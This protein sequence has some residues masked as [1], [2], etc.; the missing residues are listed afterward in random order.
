MAAAHFVSHAL[1]HTGLVRRRNEDAV[2]D[3]PERGLWAVADGMGGHE[4]GDYASACIAAAL[5]GLELPHSFDEFVA[6]VE[7]CLH[8]V[9]G[10]LRMRASRLGPYA[11]IAS[12][13]VVLLAAECE[14]VAIWAGDS[15]LYRWRAGEFRQVTTDHSQVQ[16]MVEAGLLSAEEARTHPYSHIV[17]RAIGI[18]PIELGMIRIQFA[19]GDRFLLCSDGLTN[20][21]SDNEI[22]AAIA[23]GAPRPAAEQL[24]DLVLARGAPDNVTITIAAAEPG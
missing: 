15:R 16:E 23:A 18:G 17:T 6:A 3:R 20:I 2:L 9:D 12:T 14:V 19:A 13:V 10:E 4:E 21:V 5:D 1:T 8:A 24:R 11:V 7:Q 22:A